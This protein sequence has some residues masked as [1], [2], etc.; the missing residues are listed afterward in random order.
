MRKRGGE[1]GAEFTGNA[2]A[3]MRAMQVTRHGCQATKCEAI[4]TT[5]GLYECGLVKPMQATC[6]QWLNGL[7]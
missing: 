7:Y 2:L 3:S 1:R 6:R 4:T 5:C